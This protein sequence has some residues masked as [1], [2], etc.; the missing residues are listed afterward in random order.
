MQGLAYTRMELGK[1]R[2]VRLSR[3]VVLKVPPI[4]G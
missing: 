4:G 2:P 1:R 3:V